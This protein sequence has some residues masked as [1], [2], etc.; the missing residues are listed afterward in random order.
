[1]LCDGAKAAEGVGMALCAQSYIGRSADGKAAVRR[2]AL[3][4]VS[5]ALLSGCGLSPLAERAEV[6]PVT[7]GAIA[8][9]APTPVKK[10][11][12]DALDPSDWERIRLTAS[13]T[14]LSS[15]EGDVFDWTNA[16]TGSNGTI[17]A[18]GAARQDPAAGLCRPFS[19]TVSDLRGIRRYRGEACRSADGMWRLIGVLPEDSALL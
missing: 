10:T 13:T 1:M 4:V 7:T 15:A 11:V 18:S 12:V 14:M 5:T 19:L 17:A 16:E 6:D 3:V 2:R 8:R 9:P